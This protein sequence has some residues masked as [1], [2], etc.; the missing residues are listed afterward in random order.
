MN[1][2]RVDPF[3]QKENT[4]D[5]PVS[6]EALQAWHDGHGLIQ[7]LMPNLTP[8]EREFIMTGIMPESWDELFSEHEAARNGE[9]H[10]DPDETAF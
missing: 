9:D 6:E 1:I 2:T 7:N 4:R 5:I 8:D 10:E 3:T